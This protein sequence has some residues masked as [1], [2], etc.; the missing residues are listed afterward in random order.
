M[1]RARWRK[2]IN[3]D[4]KTFEQ[5][6][7]KKDNAKK[8]RRRLGGQAAATRH[9]S[10][11]AGA[12]ADHMMMVY[13]RQQISFYPKSSQFVSA[14]SFV[15]CS[16]CTARYYHSQNKIY[17]QKNKNPSQTLPQYHNGQ[18]HAD[19]LLRKPKF[20]AFFYGRYELIK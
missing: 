17:I 9:F 10:P 13:L 1:D 11:P 7:G 12:H 14:G 16:Q 20:P 19:C 6:E 18:A 3:D 2:I 5:E 8:A 4:A 15:E